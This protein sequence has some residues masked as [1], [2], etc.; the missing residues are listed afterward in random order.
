MKC[1]ISQRCI[2]LCNELNAQQQSETKYAVTI[3]AWYSSCTT[4]MVPKIGSFF[5][6]K[7][8]RFKPYRKLSTNNGRLASLIKVWKVLK[9]VCAF[10]YWT[11][12]SLLLTLS[13]VWRLSSLRF[14][15]EATNVQIT[16]NHLKQYLQQRFFFFLIFSK[17]FILLL[18]IFIITCSWILNDVSCNIMLYLPSCVASYY[19]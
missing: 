10:N 7:K 8:R 14:S 2:V 17:N 3:F 11:L 5:G 15:N 12:P 9:Y 18:A 1:T 13:L 4:T 6:V 16:V 19:F